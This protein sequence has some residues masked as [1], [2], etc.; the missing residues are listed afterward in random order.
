LES[1][2]LSFALFAMAIAMVAH[3][4]QTQFFLLGSADEATMRWFILM[5]ALLLDP[6]TVLLLLAATHRRQFGTG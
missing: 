1:G 2:G 6:A 5:V 4:S 3:R